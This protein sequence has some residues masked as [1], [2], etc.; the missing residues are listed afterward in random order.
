MANKKSFW[1]KL[2]KAWSKKDEV[3]AEVFEDP[4]LIGVTPETQLGLL[5]GDKFS[6]V[7]QWI[8]DNW[9]PEEIN[10][11][12]G[13]VPIGQTAESWIG[14]QMGQDLA[15]ATDNWSAGVEE[16][17][18][19]NLSPDEKDALREEKAKFTESKGIETSAP[20]A[21]E[22]ESQMGAAFDEDGTVQDAIGAPEVT[23]QDI[24]KRT[25]IGGL[26][27]Q[28]LDSYLSQVADG[29]FTPEQAYINVTG[30]NLAAFVTDDD[31]KI[32]FEE[33][34]KQDGTKV[35]IPVP[36]TVQPESLFMGGFINHIRR[37]NP[38]AIDELKQF[39][40]LNGIAEAD[41]F[42]DS[43]EM[44]PALEGIIQTLMNSAN[45][46]YA[47]VTYG[48]HEWNDLVNSVPRNFGWVLDSDMEREKASWALLGRAIID[49]K[50][51][52]AFIEKADLKAK[53]KEYEANMDVPG[54]GEM[55][56]KID[57]FFSDALGRPPTPE[58]RNRFLNEWNTGYDTYV[59]K[60]ISAYKAAAY[61]A[62][63]ERY[64]IEN[65]ELITAE[66]EQALKDDI[67]ASG[68][69]LTGIVGER[70][71]ETDFVTDSDIFYDTYWNM[72][73]YTDKVKA[74]KDKREHQANLMK[75]ITGKI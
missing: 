47:H 11:Y 34:T 4:S 1:Y 72:T 42:D 65:G 12:F 25:P 71:V 35:F 33:V 66:E 21:L 22:I 46:K 73:Q 20:S 7:V 49:Y 19:E 37:Q 70:E 60:N 8:A 15:E 26:S 5:L 75:L 44:D 74:G 55:S 17:E 45:Y 41:D 30:T 29:G 59:Q 62:D 31:G 43:G 10:E 64:L 28:Q 13:D 24:L 18:Y 50:D 27:G 68:D 54:V 39:L 3:W 61:G 56:Y 38:A 23:N 53:E 48:S 58:E 40:V 36:V 32:Q 57:N 9:S 16:G 63:M 67:Q 69:V 2:G 51:D 6:N 14:I 52:T